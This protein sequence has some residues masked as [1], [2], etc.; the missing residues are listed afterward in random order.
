LVS[1]SSVAF[2]KA[3]SMGECVAMM[4]WQWPM[5]SIRRISFR[6]SIWRAGESADSGSS[7]MKMPCRWQRS[8]KKSR[9]PSP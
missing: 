9:K 1:R 2:G 3:I 7:K 5:F 6:N 8:S 4:I